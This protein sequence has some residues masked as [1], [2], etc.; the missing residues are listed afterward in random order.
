MNVKVV[1][2]GGSSLA[3][4]KQI[5]KAADI[6]KSDEKRRYVVPSAPGKRFSDDIKVT[7]MLY[8]C[9][10][11]AMENKSI[12]NAFGAIAE[13]YNGIISDLGLDLSLENEF[14]EIKKNI[15]AKAGSEYAASRGEYLNGIVI[16]ALLGYEFIDAATVIVFNEDGSFNNEKTQPKLRDRLKNVERAV[17]P[18]FYGADVNGV[19][20]TFSRGRSDVTVQLLQVQ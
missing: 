7:D 15:S 11:L 9:N 8:N 13:R 10:S 1:K 5:T 12:D 16:A 20:R 4:A 18:G 17:I 6:I 19:V 3:D 14:A 2:F